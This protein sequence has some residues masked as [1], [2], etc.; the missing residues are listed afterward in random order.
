MLTV[1]SLTSISVC[2]YRCRAD[3]KAAASSHTAEE[4]PVTQLA[5]K[6]RS[7]QH[8]DA[9]FATKLPKTTA[10]LVQELVLILAETKSE[11][12]F[13]LTV[14][15]LSELGQDAKSAIPSIVRNAERLRLLKDNDS[16]S[17]KQ[18][19]SDL[20]MAIQVILGN[21]S[22]PLMA[23]P[24]T[25]ANGKR[26]RARLK[27]KASKTLTDLRYVTAPKIE[28]WS[29]TSQN[30]GHYATNLLQK[31]EVVE[32]LAERP[33]G[34]LAIRPPKGSFSFVDARY[35]ERLTSDDPYRIIALVEVE[36]PILIGSAVRNEK[37]TAIGVKLKRGA[38]VTTVGQPLSADGEM[39]VPIEPP[40]GEV[41][42][43]RVGSV[44]PKRVELQQMGVREQ[45]EKK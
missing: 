15:I 8:T 38:E 7:L 28:V 2:P 4:G 21:G 37:P 29:G 41:R 9:E 16:G 17:S 11:Q 45:R 19:S 32:V 39:L 26:D 10:E 40:R 22:Q 31:G 43:I 35:L 1:L 30:D 14:G 6:Q 23:T 44:G 5:A 34:W 36:V 24:D 33:D 27:P 20:L 12:T 42:Y 13:T 25:P 18:M 3:G